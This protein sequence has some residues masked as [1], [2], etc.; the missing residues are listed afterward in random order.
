MARGGSKRDRSQSSPPPQDAESP[1]K[2]TSYEDDGGGEDKDT[3]DGILEIFTQVLPEASQSF[4]PPTATEV[5]A[6]QTLSP[7]VRTKLTN[8]LLRYFI[9]L[10]SQKKSFT[11]RQAT[12]EVLGEYKK[13]KVG[14][15]VFGEAKK[16]LKE[17]YGWS[18]S[19][20]PEFM[21]PSIPNKFKDHLY[22]IN[23]T[24]F[25]ENGTH[26]QNLN[27]RWDSSKNGLLICILCFVYNKGI[28]RSDTK[29]MN[30]FKWLTE[31][32]LFKLLNQTDP[33]IPAEVKF[34]KDTEIEG[35]GSVAGGIQEFVDCGYLILDKFKTDDDSSGVY[36]AWG[37]RA[38]LEVG[39]KQIITFTANILDEQPDPTMLQELDEG[40]DDEEER[41]GEEGEE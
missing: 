41:K 3:K 39:R 19:S 26:A 30:I 37:P 33:D 10:G 24:V 5:S 27:T 17:L 38:A 18:V 32:N 14:N 35:V 8:D 11:R 1:R 12:E 2:K 31:E 6:F 23:E 20:V 29:R 16:R 4:L 28:I 40:G 21:L 22:I 34:A 7:L 36:Y 25:D 13:M 15:A 9:F